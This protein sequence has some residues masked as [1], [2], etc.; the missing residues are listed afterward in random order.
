MNGKND[1]LFLSPCLSMLLGKI[2]P[3]GSTRDWTNSN[4]HDSIYE[5]SSSS[6]NNSVPVNLL[7]NTSS[8][9]YCPC[10]CSL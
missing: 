1:S 7:Q 4:D 5:E 10:L 2:F 8:A 3:F 6:E 9:I